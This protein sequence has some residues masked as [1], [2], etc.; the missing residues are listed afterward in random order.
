MKFVKVALTLALA[1]SL[2]VPAMAEP[3]AASLRRR[4][5]ESQI[6]AQ[7]LAV[8]QDSIERRQR[9][10]A[11]LQA[12]GVPI[13]QYLPAIEGQSE[14]R[15]RTAGEVLDRALALLVVS[16]RAEGLGTKEAGRM[17]A[18]F[19]IEAALS[20]AERAF[21][22]DPAP[23]EHVVMQFGWRGE[24]A[25]PLLWALG[26][27]ERMDKPEGTYSGAELERLVSGR[28]R[29]Q[30][31][32]AAR[33]RPLPEILDAAD[34]I[35]R[36]HWAVREARRLDQPVPAGLNADVVMERHQGLNWLIGYMDQ[37]WD[38]V[39]TDT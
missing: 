18:D 34:M 2:A 26:F 15:R 25:A 38:D 16:S 1:A 39:T 9:S 4:M 7:H 20:P 14:A 22:A 29:A 23:T 32:A 8:P 37:A 12:E 13:N 24:A 6:V 17:V 33:L 31:L 19:G 28:T 5:A 10:I 30:L 21:L 11:R 36:Y 3:S 35:Y 27:I